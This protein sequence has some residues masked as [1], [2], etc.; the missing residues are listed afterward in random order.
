MS[1]DHSRTNCGRH[2]RDRDVSR[3]L[4][5]FRCG[6]HVQLEE[7]RKEIRK[8]IWF[9]IANIVTTSKAIVTSSFLL[10]KKRTF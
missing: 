7:S 9:L 1:S 3:C 5:V 10:T 8:N 4:D 6:E 2:G